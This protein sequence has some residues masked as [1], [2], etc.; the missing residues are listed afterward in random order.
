MLVIPNGQRIGQSRKP[1]RFVAVSDASGA[2]DSEATGGCARRILSI[3]DDD[4]IKASAA[5]GKVLKHMMNCR[6]NPQSP[7]M[8]NSPGDPDSIN[9]LV[10]PHYPSVV[11]GG[12]EMNFR[13]GP[14][15][16]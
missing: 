2:P 1:R 16:P 8:T 13:A 10:A 15:L 3:R 4:P 7:G 12:Q 5:Q 11:I 9:I 14:A 6:R